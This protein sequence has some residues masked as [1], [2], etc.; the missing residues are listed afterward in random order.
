MRQLVVKEGFKRVIG[1]NP[2]SSLH[3][4]TVILSGFK[5]CCLLLFVKAG[6]SLKLLYEG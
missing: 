6:V 3:F 1:Y 5:I 4:R 2:A